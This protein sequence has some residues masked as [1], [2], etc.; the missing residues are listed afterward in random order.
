MYCT[1]LALTASTASIIPICFK[2]NKTKQNVLNSKT[3]PSPGVLSI[4]GPWRRQLED[5]DW[6]RLRLQ[7][8]DRRRLDARP[9]RHGQKRD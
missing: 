3:H 6:D 1:V 4:P 2:T 8:V 5:D 9:A 7:D